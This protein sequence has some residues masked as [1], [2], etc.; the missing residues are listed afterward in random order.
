MHYTSKWLQLRR[1]GSDVTYLRGSQIPGN[2]KPRQEKEVDAHLE[3][4][5]KL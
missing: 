5:E 4:P 3:Q 2:K 1:A